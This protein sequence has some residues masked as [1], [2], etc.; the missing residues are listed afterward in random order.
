MGETRLDRYV[1][2][3]GQP[4]APGPCRPELGHGGPR[5][6]AYFDDD[7]LPALSAR[8]PAKHRAPRARRDLDLKRG[9]DP[10]RSAPA[11]KRGMRLVPLRHAVGRRLQHA[12]TRPGTCCSARTWIRRA[13]STSPRRPACMKP[14]FLFQ[15]L[16]ESPAWWSEVIRCGGSTACP[17]RLA[18]RL[19]LGDCLAFMRFDGSTCCAAMAR[20]CIRTGLSRRGD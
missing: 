5:M 13:W 12:S 3:A 8:W 9:E 11:R 2:A 4:G 16:V 17:H 6:T 14:A 15:H 20:G 19:P 10:A 18:G 7:A 1:Q